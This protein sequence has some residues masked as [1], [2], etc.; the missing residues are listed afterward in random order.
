[1]LFGL[2][3]LCKMPVETNTVGPEQLTVNELNCNMIKR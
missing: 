2:G 1:M 3:M